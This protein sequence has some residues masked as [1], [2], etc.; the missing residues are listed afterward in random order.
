MNKAVNHRSMRVLLI[1]ILSIFSFAFCFGSVNK[2]EK[3][4]AESSYTPKVSVQNKTVHRGQTFSVDVNIEDNEGLISLFLTLDYNNEVMT[5]KNVIQKDALGSLTLTT[6]NVDT[7]AGYGIL[8]FNMLWD[9]RTS[10]NSNGT[11]VTL[12]F[13]SY[14][15]APLGYYPINLS[16]DKQNTNI[17]YK[18]PT[19]IFIS[20]G[21]IELITGEFLA[22]YQD[23]YGDIL[24]NKDYNADDIPEYP[25]TLPL[26][27]RA[28]DAEYIYEF[29]G[30]EGVPSDDV[31]TLIYEAKYKLIP[32]TYTIFYYIDGING[33][34]DGT[35]D[36]D[37]FYLASELSYGS[38]I[39]PQDSPL[40]QYYQFFGWY[41]DENFSSVLAYGTMPSHDIRL[42][43]YYSFDVREKDIPIISLENMEIYNN[44][45]YVSI[46]A[47]ILENTGFNGLVLTL[48]YDKEALIFD[49]FEQLETLSSM[50]FEWTGSEK[51][52]DNFKFYYESAEN[53]YETGEF[54][55]L[56]FRLK[57]NIEDATYNVWF[58]YDYHTD[59]TYVNSD[60]EIKYTMIEFYNGE[61][62]IGQKNH[63]VH[64]L[65]TE[66]SVDIVSDDGKPVNVYLNV[67]LVTE[68]VVIDENLIKTDVGEDMY[69]SSAYEIK[70]IQNRKEI[71]PNTTLRIRIKLTEKEQKSNIKFYYLND[72]YELISYDFKI[73]NGELVF[74]TDH[75]SYWVIFSDYKENGG[76]GHGQETDERDI[77]FG[78]KGNAVIL[79]GMP[80]ILSIATM[81]YALRL[82]QKIA[83]I[84]KEAHND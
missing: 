71:Q 81:L 64:N 80:I 27:E 2:N 29:L 36:N 28:E 77:V 16:F 47:K 39:K 5:L 55:K 8:P 78:S 20:D 9:G 14:I 41:A 53:T 21:T 6:T 22:V 46:N 13:D 63:W 65:D 57:E 51:E 60:K 11:I 37:D 30:W 24:Y 31:N 43:G 69:L 45:E 84:K 68:S 75:L 67:D 66:R 74:T 34:P 44:L 12:I 4:F 23:Y 83:K 56:Y 50:Q 54:L 25:T 42:Y 70:L 19:D 72:D 76:S 61:I 48:N 38:Y 35:I 17:A 1:L 62:P 59:A 26:P 7:E 3:T 82:R 40:K 32:Q 15:D 49:H 18:T 52:S 10:D 79:I 73:V 58:D 33:V